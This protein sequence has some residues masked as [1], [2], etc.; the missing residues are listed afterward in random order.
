M[1]SLREST[2]GDVMKPV[3]TTRY[4]WVVREDRRRHWRLRRTS[5]ESVVAAALIVFVAHAA[6]VLVVLT[7]TGVSWVGWAWAAW[8]LAFSY[9][10]ARTLAAIT[11]ALSD[12]PL[13]S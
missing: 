11:R 7:Q 12:E 1:E 6:G 5:L 10:T 4:S 2:G 13:T 8:V 9:V 3:S